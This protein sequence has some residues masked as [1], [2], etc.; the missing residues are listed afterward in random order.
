MT[1]SH[2]AQLRWILT[3]RS[4][5]RLGL[6][7]KVEVI[8]TI[9]NCGATMRFSRGSFGQSV[10]HA[11][12]SLLASIRTLNRRTPKKEC[13]VPIRGYMLDCQRECWIKPG[14]WACTPFAL[15]SLLALEPSCFLSC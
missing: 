15:L 7:F 14:D 2:I 10:D 6:L 5:M 12:E 13:G 1:F 3:G 11:R 8:Q 9:G 4:W